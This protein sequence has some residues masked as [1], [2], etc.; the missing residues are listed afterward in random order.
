MSYELS[1]VGVDSEFAQRPQFS[2][3]NFEL[4]TR[5]S[6]ADP[7]LDFDYIEFDG[8]HAAIVTRPV[9]AETPWVLY[10]EQR[11]WATFMC[12]P[13]ELHQLALGFLLSEGVIGGLEDVW[14]L[15]V[16]LD[17]NRVYMYFPDA[18][19]HGELALPSC[20]EAAGTIDVRLRHPAPDRPERRFLT[21]DCGVTFDNRA[22]D[23]PPLQSDRQITAA[24][25][26]SLMRQLN[27]SATLYR[28]SRGV[29]T[30]A[31]SDGERLLV[32]MEDVGRY[33]TLDKIRGACLLDGIATR[34]RVLISTG[35][36]SS[37]MLVKARKM[38]TP[39]VI[40]RTSPTALSIRLARQWNMTL[41]GY[42][43][44]RQLRVYTGGERVVF[45]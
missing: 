34:G 41:I 39:I 10:V 9:I 21:S 43:R 37:A 18:G 5:K 19:L 3:L 28:T 29:H 30:S 35:R 8:E 20:A 38:D 17:E 22:D 15:K 16:Y 2:T 42:V 40:S 24:Q 7:T 1:N 31:L 4:V 44:G 23:L 12:S 36:I 25:V 14:Q 33:N 26:S 6:M 11:E 45:R 32:Q 27:E 13:I